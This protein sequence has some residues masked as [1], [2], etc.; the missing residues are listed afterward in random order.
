MNQATTTLTRSGADVANGE[1]A[2]K[3]KAAINGTN[4]YFICMKRLLNAKYVI[5]NQSNQTA[6]SIFHDYG[7]YG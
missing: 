4:L 7:T 1:T 3:P 6:I 5:F 2:I